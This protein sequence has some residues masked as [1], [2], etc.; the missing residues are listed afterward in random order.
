MR[1]AVH[2]L[3]IQGIQVRTGGFRARQPHEHLVNSLDTADL[4][5]E[6]AP[7]RWAYAHDVGLAAH[8]EVGS[9]HHALFFGCDPGRF[10]PVPAAI[11]HHL[12]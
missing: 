6:C 8:P 5:A 2:V 4:L 7:V 9:G 11:L 3:E 1:V 12:A 10:T